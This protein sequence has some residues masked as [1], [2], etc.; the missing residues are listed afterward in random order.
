MSDER[1]G[2]ARV[3]EPD[4]IDEAGR[5]LEKAII[6]IDVAARPMGAAVTGLIVSVNGEAPL[7]EVHRHLVVSPT[8]LGEAMHE[9]HHARGLRR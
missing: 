2:K 1:D 3:F 8:V 9:D 7:R 4:E 6:S 5:F